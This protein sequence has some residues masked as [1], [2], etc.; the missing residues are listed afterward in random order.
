MS[1]L[2]SLIGGEAEIALYGWWKTL[3]IY[4]RRFT[5][6]EVNHMEKVE[7]GITLFFNAQKNR[8][9]IQLSDQIN[10][11]G[12]VSWMVI[13]KDKNSNYQLLFGENRERGSAFNTELYLLPMHKL[14][15]FI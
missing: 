5:E 12:F 3:N 14:E 6:N 2:C 4:N 13:G 7:D 10:V 8:L 11:N 15:D 9:E 1:N